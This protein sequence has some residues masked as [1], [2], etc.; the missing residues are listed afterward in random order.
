VH[1]VAAAG[2][3]GWD[4]DFPLAPDVPA[5]YPEVLTV[6]AA[7]DSDGQVG[8]T[9][10][11]STCR[12]GEVDDRYASF[13]NYASTAGGQRH[14]IAA[15]G[16]CI[17]S[18]PRGG[19]HTVMSGTSMASPHVAGAVAVCLNEGGTSGPCAGL[20]PAGVIQK[21]RADAQTKSEADSGYGFAG[22]PLRPVTGRYFGYLTR[23]GTA[24]APPPP[25][26]PPAPTL[27]TYQPAGYT[28][29]AGT[30][31]K[32]LGAVS[33]FFNDDSSRVEVQ[34]R[35]G[36]TYL[37]EIHPHATITAGEH[38][39]LKKLSFDYDGNATNSS[40][41]VTLR[42]RNDR[43]NQWETVDGPRTGVTSDRPVTWSNST[44]PTDY[45]SGSGQVKVSVRGTRSG[46]FR[47][48]TDLVRFRIEF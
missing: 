3:S 43:T 47:T 5:V 21:L 32:G 46:T 17:N 35:S 13:S 38:A 44:S 20:S 11:N 14:T 24:W 29:A 22:D 48:R 26:P 45:V 4:F 10:G 7:S 23:G 37:A 16:V 40:A 34:A 31:Y 9:G 27:K 33:R 42:I 12:S 30:V 15:P 41:A 1:Y 25:P 36:S 18:T 6:A 2:N 39:S 19:G 28:L 8:G